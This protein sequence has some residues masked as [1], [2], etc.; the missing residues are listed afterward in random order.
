MRIEGL[1]THVVPISEKIHARKIK[2]DDR[3]LRKLDSRIFR[4]ALPR[5]KLQLRR[6]DYTCPL[7]SDRRLSHSLPVHPSGGFCFFFVFLYVALLL[8]EAREERGTES[9][10]PPV[11][12]NIFM[13]P[14]LR[15][16]ASVAAMPSFWL[17]MASTCCIGSPPNGAVIVNRTEIPGY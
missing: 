4:I 8:V 16:Q 9:K 12:K 1:A 5:H 7:E 10:S 17:P 2:G 15:F 13:E 14:P 11:S 3:H 6:I